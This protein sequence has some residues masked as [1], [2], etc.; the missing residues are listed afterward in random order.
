MA[1]VDIEQNPVRLMCVNNVDRMI[2][3][4]DLLDGY[5]RDCTKMF[6]EW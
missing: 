2:K 4:Q 5:A 6:L 3:L 1:E